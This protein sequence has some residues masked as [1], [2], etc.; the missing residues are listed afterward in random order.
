MTSNLPD[1]NRLES[2][3]VLET[4]TNSFIV[5]IRSQAG[6]T[7]DGPSNWHGSVE[8]A[9]SRERMHFVEYTLLAK[10]IAAHTQTPLLD[11]WR[12]RL[13][14]RW[15]RSALQRWLNPLKCH[16]LCALLPGKSH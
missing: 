16:A 15:Q 3:M 4:T 9:Q 13:A 11:P 12:M 6:R 5:V 2:S 7:D 1:E 14:R 10:F 8:H